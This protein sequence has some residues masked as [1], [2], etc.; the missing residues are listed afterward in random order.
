MDRRTA[1][2]FLH[3]QNWGS[4]PTGLIGTNIVSDADLAVHRECGFQVS[5]SPAVLVVG[6]PSPDLADSMDRV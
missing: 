5:S 1:K 3:I 4:S 2:E 6:R